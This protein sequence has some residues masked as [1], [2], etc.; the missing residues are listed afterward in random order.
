M[1]KKKY[2]WN[3]RVRSFM[4]F[5]ALS[6]CV[7]KINFNVPPAQSL[8]VVEGM[9]TDAPGPYTIKVSKS[10]SLTADSSFRDPIEKA[11]IKLHDDDGNVEDFSEAAP[12]VYVTGGI[13]Q[14]RVGHVYYIAIETQDGKIF[15][16]E[17]DR[18]NPVGE[19]EQI[20]Y[21]YEARTAEV[22]TAEVNA[23]VFNIFVDADG[24][25]ESSSYVRWRFSGTYKVETHP[26]LHYTVTQE[27]PPYAYKS[28]YPCSG[29]IVEAALGG[30]YLRKVGE[31]T[32]CTCWVNQFESVPTLSD[33]QL[34]SNNHYQ[35]V[36][37]GEI[38]INGLTFTEKYM[39]Q[40]D[41]M[42]MTENAF[43]FFKLIRKQKENA[44]SLFQPLNGEIKGNIAPVNS[45]EPVVGIFWAASIRSKYI[46]ILKSDV[47]YNIAPIGIAEPCLTYDNSSMNKPD[48]WQ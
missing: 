41:Q 23:D 11:K 25:S 48:F 9:I 29:Y 43:Q 2:F 20:R 6:A 12:G 44:S 39:V 14:G 37:V 1:S 8:T 17:P 16:S 27:G 34:V 33:G 22:N 21:E 15:R 46:Y 13:I 40:V 7:D 38:P 31:C 45:T 35:N 5:I 10:L 32:C 18:I 36:K 30:G 42:S 26:E 4:A 47:P 3:V 19:I 24:G 28:P